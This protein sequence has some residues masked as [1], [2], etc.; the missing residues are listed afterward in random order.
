MFE[1]CVV[2]RKAVRR[3][4]VSLSLFAQAVVVAGALLFPLVFLEALP[5]VRLADRTPLPPPSIRLIGTPARQPATA[6]G[7]A[8]LELSARRPAFVAP[9]RIP[10][11]IAY[12]SGESPE[13]PGAGGVGF[14]VTGGTGDLFGV[15]TGISTT[16][17]ASE[18]PAPAIPPPTKVAPAAPV[19][20]G[21]DVRPPRL[22]RE[23][24]PVYPPLARSA[25]VS[26]V[27]RLDSIIGRDGEIRSLRVVSGHP[28]LSSAAVD[29]VRQWRYSPTLL[30]GEPVEVILQIEVNF[31]L[32]Q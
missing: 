27:V 29:A 26:G 8:A 3:W 28:L 1:I 11:G 12:V 21:G 30:N 6:R 5:P 9:V 16:I 31:L 19:R 4:T 18:P 14:G 10:A 24:Q 2:S 25:R 15:P 22:V 13:M 17:M 32:R 7:G 23:V 20:I